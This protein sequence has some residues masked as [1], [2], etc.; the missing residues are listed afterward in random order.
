MR[1]DHISLS[2]ADLDKQRAFYSS[3]LG[4]TEVEAKLSVPEASIRSVILCSA[5]GLRIELVERRG[6]SASEFD[7][8]FDAASRQG[9]GHWALDVLNLETALDRV[10]RHGARLVSQPAP[11]ARPGAWFAYVKDPE[12]N[13]IELIEPAF[14]ELPGRS[15]AE[16]L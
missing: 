10:L 12:G 14:I 16:Y 4:M 9:Y 6:S 8:P 1:F 11:A 3:A 7:D 15:R 5:T 13:L 2:V